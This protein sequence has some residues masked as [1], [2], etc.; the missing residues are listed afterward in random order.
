MPENYTLNGHIPTQ[1]IPIEPL[2]KSN[3][4]RAVNSD[5]WSYATKEN[6][7]TLPQVWTRGLLYFLVVFICIAL[8]WAMLSK[9]DET[10]VAKG[11]LEPKG[12]TLI[13]DAPVSGTVAAMPVKE[14]DFVEIGQPLLELESELIIS[15]LQQERERLEGQQNRLH[16]LELLKNQL[17]IAIG[18]QKQQNQAQ[19]LEKQAQ[20]EQ[21]RQNLESLKN[22]FHLQKEEKLAQVNQAQQELEHGKTAVHLAK[23]RW[24]YSQKEVE[25]YRQAVEE[26][27]VAEV[28]M[29]D[30]EDRARERQRLYEQTQSDLEQAKLRLAEQK[31]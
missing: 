26:G 30:R 6:L 7:D 24:Q 29:S 23:I 16:Q 20:V 8:P 5:E 22:S 12:K 25:R 10:G 11:R 3:N 2:T 27:I 13:L 18:T 28:Q 4:D 15:E 14:G 31:K 1:T 17:L 9:V 19:E 21:S